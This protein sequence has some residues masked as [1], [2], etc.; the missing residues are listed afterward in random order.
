MAW[1]IVLSLIVVGIIFLLLEILVVPGATV[2]GLF[3]LGLVV[4]GIV[5]SF[6]H[7]G[8]EAGIMTL[9]GTLAISLVAI[10]LALRS[11]TW[12]KAMH[13][14][15]LEGRV[16][17]VEHDKVL[18]GD[19]G[20]SITRLNP[21]GKALIKDEYYEVRSLDNL[22]AENTPITV[23]KVEGNKIIVKPKEA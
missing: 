19:E 21:M 22:I 12:K 18:K 6:N 8:V 2:V 13:S 14:S 20:V 15:A 11:N 10:G 4:A 5:V 1:L 17:V 9:A 7:Y 3:G 23:V 16:N